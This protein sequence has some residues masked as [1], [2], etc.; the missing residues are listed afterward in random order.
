MSLEKIT[1]RLM[2]DSD[3]EC[4][5]IIEKAKAQADAII[6]NAEEQA[7]NIVNEAKEQAYS[8]FNKAVERA[9]SSTVTS[10]RRAILG[11]KN[12]LINIVINTAKKRLC[13]LDDD[14][15]FELL[16]DIA[17][18]SLRDGDGVMF[19]SEKDLARCPADF[20]SKLGHSVT[21]SDTPIKTDGG[22][23]LKYG[24]IEINCTFDALFESYSDELRAKASE[25]LF[26]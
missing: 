20:V 22:F 5:D 4:A 17:K 24:G 26:A 9:K 7:E 3:K 18:H 21:L 8:E 19:L 14:R 23:I 15:Y 10:E 25:M 6:K 2:S 11:M 16:Y 13:T 12:E 1:A